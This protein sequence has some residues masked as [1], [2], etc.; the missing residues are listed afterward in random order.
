VHSTCRIHNTYT[1]QQFSVLITFLMASMKSTCSFS[2]CYLAIK[3]HILP[4]TNGTEFNVVDTGEYEMDFLTNVFCLD[5][6]C[7]CLKLYVW[8][9]RVAVCMWIGAI[10]ISCSI[11]VA[12]SSSS[13]I[14][15]M[16]KW[17]CVQVTIA[18]VCF[19]CWLNIS[20]S[21]LVSL[22][23]RKWKMWRRRL[24]RNAKSPLSMCF[25]KGCH[26]SVV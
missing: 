16:R 17:L 11:L 13:K 22:E 4:L 7:V 12:C 8:Y 15:H 23:Q 18:M 19:S 2:V 25:F 5:E 20:I 10:E 14:L 6:T 1:W 24:E 9:L 26:C 3:P 21:Q